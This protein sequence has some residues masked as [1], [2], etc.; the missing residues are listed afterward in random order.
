[1]A[2][3]LSAE[4]NGKLKALQSALDKIEKDFEKG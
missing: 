4:Q 3:E 2:K 1:M